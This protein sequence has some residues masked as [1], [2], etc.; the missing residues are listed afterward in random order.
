MGDLAILAPASTVNDAQSL[1]NIYSQIASRYQ[2][3]C[4]VA[5]AK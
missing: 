5:A 3:G 1:K 4:V 2:P